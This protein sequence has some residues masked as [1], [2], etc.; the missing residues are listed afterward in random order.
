V[1]TTP[2]RKFFDEHMVYIGNN[3]V[4]GMID[5]QYTDDA[6]LISPFDILDTPPPHIVRGNKALNEFFHKYLDWQGAI[7]VESLYNFAETSDSIT[8]H[9]I[10]TSKT[11]R[12]V[13]GDEWHMRDGKIDRH[14][15]FAHKLD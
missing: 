14:Y 6:V 5:D 11:G 8:F 12:W 1:S 13:V 4:D 10:F 15:S 9:A 7:D 3:D 2:G